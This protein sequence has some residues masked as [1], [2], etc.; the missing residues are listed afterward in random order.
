MQVLAC[1]DDVLP[2]SS[3]TVAPQGS[4]QQLL[5]RAKTPMASLP[6][7]PRDRPLLGGVCGL[8]RHVR[9]LDKQK[10]QP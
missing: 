3:D 7:W 4:A 5:R 2:G 9:V 8:K 10:G 1:A 6:T